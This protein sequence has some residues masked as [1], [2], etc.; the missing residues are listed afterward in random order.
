MCA[1][2]YEKTEYGGEDLVISG[3]ENGIAPSPHKGIANIQNANISTE[4]Q[5][6]MCSFA[7]LAEINL[8][9]IGSLSYYSANQIIVAP[10][11]GGFALPAG[12]W[13]T[14]SGSLSGSYYILNSQIIGGQQVIQVAATYNGS[15][16][17]GFTSGFAA[18]F[19]VLTPFGLPIGSAT[20]IY[21]GGVGYRYYILDGN[22]L[23][24]VNDTLNTPIGGS[25]FCPD[26]SVAYWSGANPS[27]IA[28]LNGWL[29]VVAG[30]GV[31]AKPTV[32]L[33]NTTATTTTWAQ[34]YQ[35]DGN[36]LQLNSLGISTNPHTAF[37]GHQGKMYY[38]DGNYLGEIFPDTSVLVTGLPNIQSYC[39]YSFVTT[40]G[41][42][43]EVLSGS[44]PTNGLASGDAGFLRVPAIF[45]SSPGGSVGS[46]LTQGTVYFIQY[47]LGGAGTFAV[48]SAATGGS[49]LNLASGANGNQYFNTFYPTSTNATALATGT[50]TITTQRLNLPTFE[51]SQCMC[52]NGNVLLIGCNG[53]TVY[54][55]SQ[56]TTLPDSLIT[57]P[58]SNVAQLIN[59][60]NMAYIFAGNKGNIYITN[61]SVAS[62]VTTVP[63][64]CAGIPGTASTYIEPYFVW[65][66]AMYLR[67]RVYFSVRDQTSTKLGNCGGIWS[68][69]PTQNFYVGQDIGIGLRLESQ[70]SYGTYSGF[71]PVLL[72]SQNQEAIGPQFWSAW[73]ANINTSGY[74][75]DFTGT[76]PNG[77]TLIETDAIPTGT[78]LDKKTFKQVEYKLGTALASGETIEILYRQDLTSTY[79]TLA[80][81][82]E[83]N[84]TALSGYFPVN[85][86]KGQWLQ[87]Q[88]SLNPVATSSSSF[89]RFY[90]LRIR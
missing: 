10:I 52:E 83:D 44:L 4:M 24:W 59:V 86:Q 89:C 38:C 49:P 2:K 68:F 18:T 53:N 45:F 57:L 34:V 28:I 67:G 11:G 55:W 90:E 8:P 82:N 36:H 22:G 63:D 20:E 79:T 78:M 73:Q 26:A 16:V 47:T 64:Y 72:A 75:I 43:N 30:Y 77:S 41:T 39:Q 1:Y 66:G 58:E 17:G 74:G 71:C 3:W 50:V 60:N 19:S 32:N 81:I 54:P 48:Y 56:V 35:E 9:G 37:V 40:T 27:G 65:G 23:V 42:I 61:G 25:W 7:R 5:E 76:T 84:S 51:V 31:Y 6:I 46:A 21:N 70:S 62:L 87:L 13:I 85:F 12:V 33:G 15:V 88:I 29:M 14:A 69:I 80:M